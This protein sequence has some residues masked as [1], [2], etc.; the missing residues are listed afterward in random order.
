MA[1]D[2]C[3]LTSFLAKFVVKQAV[4]ICGVILGMQR[5]KDRSRDEIETEYC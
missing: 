1:Q 3:S 4:E 5:R 2:S